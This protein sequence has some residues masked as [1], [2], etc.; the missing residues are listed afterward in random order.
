M[1]FKTFILQ[2]SVNKSQIKSIK[3]LVTT[4]SNKETTTEQ[5]RKSGVVFFVS[6]LGS[7]PMFSSKFIEKLKSNHYKVEE[8]DNNNFK[9]SYDGIVMWVKYEKN[10]VGF[11]LTTNKKIEEPEWEDVEEV[12]DVE[13]KE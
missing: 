5:K 8:I 7:W 9:A 6:N 3:E 1:R 13:E 11:Y 2:E 4:F 12:K 10:D